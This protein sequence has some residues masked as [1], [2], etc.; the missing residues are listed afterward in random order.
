MVP[1]PESS[2][3]ANGKIAM[4]S[5]AVPRSSRSGACSLGR[6]PKSMGSAVTKSKIPPL[7][8]K[9]STVTPKWNRTLRPAKR[10]NSVTAKAITIARNRVVRRSTVSDRL[11][12]ATNMG[13]TP[14]GSTTTNIVTNA[15]RPNCSKFSP[16]GAERTTHWLSSN[17]C[18]QYLC[19]SDGP[20][21]TV[22]YGNSWFRGVAA[23]RPPSYF[24]LSELQS[25]STSSGAG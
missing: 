8:A 5:P 24:S 10:K 15:F 2:G 23:R 1:G 17:R 18:N 16:I 21:T 25:S 11:V 4:S 3:I 13:A 9:A 19:Q 7:I 22:S 20:Q 14:T 6:C 12:S